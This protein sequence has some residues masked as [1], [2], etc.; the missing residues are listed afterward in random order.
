MWFEE[1]ADV[2]EV[3]LVACVRRTPNAYKAPAVFLLLLAE[4][5]SL[6][7]RGGGDETA[8]KEESHRTKLPTVTD[9]LTDFCEGLS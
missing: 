7:T 5:H 4:E 8:P 1:L 3:V 2:S 6:D 9:F